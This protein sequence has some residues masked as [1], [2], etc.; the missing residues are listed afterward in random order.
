MQI[1]TK[2]DATLLGFKKKEHLIEFAKKEPEKYSKLCPILLK[3]RQRMEEL[4]Q[5]AKQEFLAVFDGFDLKSFMIEFDHNKYFQ[6]KMIKEKLQEQYRGK[7]SNNSSISG[8]VTDDTPIS[9]LPQKRVFNQEVLTG[10]TQQTITNLES[11]IM[12][13]KEQEKKITNLENDVD[14]LTFELERLMKQ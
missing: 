9:S 11:T 3:I 10:I 12:F 6:N 14:D 2:S 1:N 13:I 4:E 7:L 8:S 5:D